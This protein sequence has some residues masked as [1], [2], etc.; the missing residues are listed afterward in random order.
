[1]VDGRPL[2]LRT[3]RDAIAAGIGFVTEDR[4][5]EGLVLDRSVQENIGLPV[6]RSLSRW[7][8]MRHTAERSLAADFIGSLRIRTPSLRQAVRTLSGGNQQKVVLA[9]WLATGARVLLLDEPTR[10]VDVGAKAEMHALIRQLASNGA[11]IL[12]LSSDLPE[13]LAL[14][15]RTYV[16]RDGRIA[17][18]L[19]GAAQV[20]E[21]VMAL[22]VG[23]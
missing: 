4:K 18:E 13:L 9:K 19:S 2:A 14:A 22:A 12:L 15:D 1:M 3:P 21:R 5:R 17:G 10:G 7:G 11:A 6:L 23:A 20:A 16:M 8:V